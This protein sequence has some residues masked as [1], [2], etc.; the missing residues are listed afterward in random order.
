[1]EGIPEVTEK[2]VVIDGAETVLFAMF[3]FPKL[4]S[5]QAQVIGI[6]ATVLPHNLFMFP[7][8][9]KIYHFMSL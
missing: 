2:I 5:K 9:L 7:L 4:M 3:T 6:H 8:P 1:V